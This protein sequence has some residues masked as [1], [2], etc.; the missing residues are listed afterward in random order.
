MSLIRWG[1][2]GACGIAQRRTIPEGIAVAKNA[3][4]AAVYDVSSAKS[5]AE[6]FGVTCCETESELL[7]Q[8]VEAIYIATPVYLHAEQIER[9]ANAGKHVLC[10]KPLSLDVVEAER[11]AK[12]CAAK[13]V[14]LGVGLMMRFHACHIEAKSII[15]SG[16][17]GK[18]V[19]ARA[20]LSCWYPPMANAW[21]QDPKLG[22]GGALMDLGCHCIDL[23]EMLFG[24]I[25]RISCQI[26]NSV[27]KYAV[28]D[29]AVVSLTFAN[30]A[31]GIVDCLFNVPDES[32]LNRLELYG[33][34]GSLLCEG[35]IGQSSE[36]A[37]V[38]RRRSAAAGYDAS[39][40]RTEQTTSHFRPEPIN[41]YRAQIEAFSQSILD[42]KDPPIDGA[43]GIRIQRLLEACYTSARTGRVIDV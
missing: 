3:K 28:E 36:G 23:L 11:L 24:P 6:K 37:I 13:R 32:S 5:V 35:T 19:L 20:Q 34:E 29:S 18:P 26:G 16:K 7:D 21:R 25:V 40:S 14:R 15:D 1:V 4:L 22:G 39:Q 41:T 10:E 31:L 33:S 9:A 30:G 8:D 27:Q 2:I 42:Q 12:L 43:A 17:L 38:W